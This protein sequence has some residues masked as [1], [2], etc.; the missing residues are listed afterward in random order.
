MIILAHFRRYATLLLAVVVA[1]AVSTRAFADPIAEKRAQ[2]AAVQSQ[3]DALNTKAEI[4]TEK[5]NAAK[6]RHD[7]LTREVRSTERRIAKLQG[8]TKTLQHKLDVTANSMYREGPLNFLS[9]LL[10]VESFEDF[11]ST[12]EV[13]TSINEQRGQ[14]VTQLKVAKAEALKAH[15]TLVAA[16]K[17]AARQQCSHGAQRRRGQVAAGEAESG[18]WTA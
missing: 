12:W 16:Q 17:D 10:N 1:L 4:A 7:Q 2:A 9:V 8:R 11:S 5:Y 13:L 6:S 18:V 3:V 14:T 15:T